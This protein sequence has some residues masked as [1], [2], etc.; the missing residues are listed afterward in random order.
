[1]FVKHFF[2][3]EIV[4]SWPERFVSRMV[5]FQSDLRKV[6]NELILKQEHWIQACGSV[7]RMMRSAA[8]SPIW[9]VSSGDY[10]ADLRARFLEEHYD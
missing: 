4:F 5:V 10:K 7:L 8:L 3:H 2:T 1:M 6:S 9:I